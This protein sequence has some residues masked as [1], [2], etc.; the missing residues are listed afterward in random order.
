MAAPARRPRPR[1]SGPAATLTRRQRTAQK[2][3]LLL[4]SFI[5]HVAP[6]KDSPGS[7]RAA[8]TLALV[9]GSR[10]Q[11]SGDDQTDRCCDYQFGPGGATEAK[12]APRGEKSLGK[13]GMEW[14]TSAELSP[15]RAR[16]VWIEHLR[17][18]SPG[19]GARAR[20]G[21]ERK[22]V[23]PV[24]RYGLEGFYVMERLMVALHSS[25]LGFW[26]GAKERGGSRHR[27]ADCCG[28]APPREVCH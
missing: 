20:I 28:S 26:G 6:T 4:F 22:R 15:Y 11:P 21:C 13:I 24:N 19:A 7:G 27:S 14:A 12:Q 5:T 18:A 23:W 2:P 9:G 10:S 17:N 16:V 1:C 25:F 3:R 8:S